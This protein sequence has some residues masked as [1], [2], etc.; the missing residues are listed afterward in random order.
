MKKFIDKNNQQV[1]LSFAKQAFAKAPQH[2]F[3][4][5]MHQNK[6]LLTNH[7]IRGFEFPGGKCKEHETIEAAAVREVFEETGGK[8]SNLIYIGEYEVQDKQQSFVKAVFFAEVDEIQEKEDYLETK[9]PVLLEGNI[10]TH[11]QQTHFSFI[12]KDDMLPLVLEEMK[13][14]ELLVDTWK[15]EHH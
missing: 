11:R 7:R 1:T 8:I 6:W 12:M 10:L 9:G 5:C 4:V 15:I 13:R 2:V 14:K 3:I